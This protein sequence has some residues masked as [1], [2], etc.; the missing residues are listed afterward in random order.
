MNDAVKGQD[1]IIIKMPGYQD[2]NIVYNMK[3]YPAPDIDFSVLIQHTITPQSK[4]DVASYML[5]VS[6][7]GEARDSNTYSVKNAFTPEMIMDS[8]SKYRYNFERK[9]RGKFYVAI[10]G[11]GPLSYLHKAQPYTSGQIIRMTIKTR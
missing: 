5:L 11:P 6:R 9:N 1:S 7:T 3:K 4:K 2:K 10:K 8:L